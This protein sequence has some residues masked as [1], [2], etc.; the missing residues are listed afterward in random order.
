MSG[1]KRC[2]II[3]A[4]YL[5]L[6]PDATKRIGADAEPIVFAVRTNELRCRKFIL[7]LFLNFGQD[8]THQ[9]SS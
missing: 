5:G 4:G 6:E 1:P 3:G 2:L 8:F 9:T 7:G